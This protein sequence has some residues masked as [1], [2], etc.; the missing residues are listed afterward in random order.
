MLIIL[1]CAVGAAHSATHEYVVAV[2]AAL[3]RLAVTAR[4][5]T[6]VTHIAARSRSAARFLESATTCDS[7]SAL[8]ARG[9]S[10]ALPDTGIDCLLYS[11]DLRG[12]AAADRRGTLLERSNIVASPSVWLWRPRIRDDDEIIVRFDLPAGVQVAVPWQPMPGRDNRYRLLASP[13]SGTAI[14][15]FG[16]F[17]TALERVAG[18]ELSISILRVADP[19]DSAPL[20]DWIRDTAANVAQAYGRFPN[21]FISVVVVPVGGSLRG[22]DMAVPFGR[23]IRDGGETV[24]LL[25][26]EHRPIADYYVDWTATHEFSHLMLPYVQHRQR[27][28]SEG[29]AQYYQNLLLARS[30]RYTADEAWQKLVEGLQRGRMSS[31]DLSPNAAAAIGERNSRMKIYWSG[32]A[33]ALLADVELRRRSNGLQSLDG[34]LEELQ[35]C[36]L[37]SARSW[38]GPELLGHLDAM[39]E[40][41]VFMP[42]YR[43]HADIPGFPDVWPLLERLGVKVEANRVIL[44]DGAQLAAIRRAM[45]APLSSSVMHADEQH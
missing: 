13:E 28:I 37:P 21:P 16:T 6:H 43:K 8:A 4:Y 9:R 17:D 29:F 41:P 20:I 18:A 15:V 45:T 11:I 5:A 24:E 36:C 14:A 33:L 38:S 27:W 12:A 22:S 35:R 39:L 10:L 34:V 26:D 1:L 40:E 25:I 42:L 3:T 19:I 7:S 31:P 44:S 32:A 30:G 23:V 2:D